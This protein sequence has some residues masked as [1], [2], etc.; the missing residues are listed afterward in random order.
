MNVMTD[1]DIRTARF[2]RLLSE[3]HQMQLDLREMK[4]IS[5]WERTEWLLTE[6]KAFRDDEQAK[7]VGNAR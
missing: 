7:V 5:A 4:L 1:K 2:N 6:T 3:L